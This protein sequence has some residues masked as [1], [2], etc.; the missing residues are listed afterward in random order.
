MRFDIW[1]VLGVSLGVLSLFL[2]WLSVMNMSTWFHYSG[3]IQNIAY[4]P[5]HIDVRFSSFDLDSMSGYSGESCWDWRGAYG[6]HAFTGPHIL[7]GIALF[8]GV[9]SLCL[10]LVGSFIFKGW[11]KV[12]KRIRLT[13]IFLWLFSAVFHFYSMAWLVNMAYGTEVLA[14]NVDYNV[15]NYIFGGVG[16]Y[17]LGLAVVILSGV[18]FFV[19][20]LSPKHILLPINVKVEKFL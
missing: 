14:P 13:V 6:F 12:G 15:G 5:L 8:L 7:H 10:A 1:G 18:L 2:P 9:C 16:Y 20:W 3:Y 4:A 17:N 19:S 11:V